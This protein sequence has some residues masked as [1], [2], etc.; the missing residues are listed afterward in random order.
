MGVMHWV[1]VADEARARFLAGDA[2]L[3]DLIEIKDL[4]HPEGRMAGRDLKSDRPGRFT[5]GV[6]S[7]TAAEP[8]T[9]A[10]TIE[11]TRF[12]AEVAEVLRVA[13]NDGEYERLI[14]V[15][16]SRFLGRLRAALDP[17]VARAVVGEIA[18]DLSKAALKNLPAAV[19][20]GLL[21]TAG[22]P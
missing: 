8:H 2:L 9:D 14:L 6:G 4:I 11:A 18:K 13:H 16:P 5:T 17:N 19:R 20:R 1:V 12:A 10:E 22:M 3:D 7:R 21:P 15:A